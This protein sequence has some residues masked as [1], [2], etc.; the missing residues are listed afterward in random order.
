MK[1]TLLTCLLLHSASTILCMD[2]V[3]AD[4]TDSSALMIDRA[5]HNQKVAAL[6]A[7][8]AAKNTEI[9]AEKL[10][11]AQEIVSL[12]RRWDLKNAI[13]PAV[14]AVLI[15]GKAA[16]DVHEFY[17]TQ[18]LPAWFNYTNLALDGSLLLYTAG[19]TGWHLMRACCRRKK[20]E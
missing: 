17:Y 12:H 14:Y 16:W 8:I 4:S 13:A 15:A 3:P 20:I 10:R 6:Q 9:S 2:I 19:K 5:T 7:Q 1:K 11:Q 18:E